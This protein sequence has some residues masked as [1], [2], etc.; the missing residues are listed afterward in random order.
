[1]TCVTLE[2]LWKALHTLE[3]RGCIIPPFDNRIGVSKNVPEEKLKKLLD[4]TLVFTRESDENPLEDYYIL[5][6]S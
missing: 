5:K 4:S 1:M 3:K 6:E 2:C